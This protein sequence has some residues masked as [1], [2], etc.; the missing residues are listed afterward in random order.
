METSRIFYLVDSHRVLIL[1]VMALRTLSKSASTWNETLAVEARREGT[2][3]ER[4]L[5]VVVATL[6]DTAGNTTTISTNILVLH[7]Q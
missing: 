2:D 3:L 7:D 1:H 6:T 4:R 5:Y